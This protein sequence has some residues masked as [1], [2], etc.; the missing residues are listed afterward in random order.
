MRFKQ[1]IAVLIVVLFLTE[2]LLAS[3]CLEGAANIGFDAATQLA[4]NEETSIDCL[5]TLKSLHWEFDD[6]TKRKQI[7]AIIAENLENRKQE[8]RNDEI[9]WR[10]EAFQT[11]LDKLWVQVKRKQKLTSSN[12]SGAEDAKMLSFIRTQ[13][14][15]GSFGKAVSSS[16]TDKHAKAVSFMVDAIPSI[17]EEVQKDEQNL[18]LE[19]MNEEASAKSRKNAERWKNAEPYLEG[20]LGVVLI[21]GSLYLAGQSGKK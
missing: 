18:K 12:W 1:T 15:D 9:R 19:L 13:D 3:G 4:S 21:G 20:L 10:V 8:A 7:R 11:K 14:M 17:R 5:N 6:Y 2:P 16:D